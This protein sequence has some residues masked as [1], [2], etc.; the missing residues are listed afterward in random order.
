MGRLSTK[1]VLTAGAAALALAWSALLAAWHLEGRA[2]PL[3]RLEATLA[4]L[5]FLAAGPRRAPEGVVVVAIDDDT[6][7]EAGR[8][9]LSRNR[10]ARLVRELYRHEPKA[11]ALDLLFLDRAMPEADEALADALRGKPAVI[12]AAAVFTPGVGVLESD[13]PLA[14]VPAAARILRPIDRLGQAAALRGHGADTVVTDLAELLG[15]P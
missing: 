1:G 8:Y 5:R 15:T 2:T 10:L 6:V 7:R 9:P 12:A 4:D 14:N 3:D 13:G 11:I